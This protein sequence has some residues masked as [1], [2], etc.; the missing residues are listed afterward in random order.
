[1]SARVLTAAVA[2]P[3]LAALIWTGG[4]ALLVFVTMVSLVAS[5]ETTRLFRA[6]TRAT[7]RL[8]T[9]IGAVFVPIAVYFVATGSRSAVVAGVLVF[10]L[11]EM[12]A[13]AW[14]LGDPEEGA[15]RR[16]EGA[17]RQAALGMGALMYIPCLLSYGLLM[18]ESPD[19]REWLFFTLGVV[20]ATD[21]C[22][23][24][25]GRYFG[26]FKMA[27]SISPGKTWEGAAAGLIAGIWAG[28]ALNSLLYLDAPAWQAAVA[29]ASVSVAG[30]IGDLAES[31]LKRIAEVKDAGRILPGHGGLLDRIDSIVAALPV[32]Y[33]LLIW[34]IQ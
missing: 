2:L 32:M 7:V 16:A 30:Q 5:F 31:K 17:A 24:L 12:L 1:M 11:I 28:I 4:I 23:L 15:V 21:T 33:Y 8:V 6:H 27:P 18:R 22:A 20:F 25:A 10:L 13:V 29:A 19:G 3:I 9:W 26:R 34:W 14:I